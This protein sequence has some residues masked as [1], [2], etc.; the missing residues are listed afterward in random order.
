LFFLFNFLTIFLGLFQIVLKGLQLRFVLTFHIKGRFFLFLVP[1]HKFDNLRV[2][3]FDDLIP[4]SELK[5]ASWVGAGRRIVLFF[6]GEGACVLP[7][8]GNL[9]G[10]S[11][12][13]V[14]EVLL[15]AG[16]D[17]GPEFKEERL[18]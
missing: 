9:R 3:F 12:P 5:A 7:L 8:E 11:G 15:K 6:M 2:E 4:K 1:V 10:G 14:A 13:E 16:V 18:D 17:G